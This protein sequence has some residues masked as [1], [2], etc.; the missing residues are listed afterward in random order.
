MSTR[1]GLIERSRHQQFLRRQEKTPVQLVGNDSP[2]VS[3]TADGSAVR[4]VWPDTSLTWVV[5]ALLDDH[6]ERSAEFFDLDPR[7]Q[8]LAVDVLRTL[9]R[10]ALDVGQLDD[11]KFLAVT[12]DAFRDWLATPMVGKLPATLADG[13]SEAETAKREALLSR[14]LVNLAATAII[15]DAL[16][17]DVASLLLEGC[18][19]L[20]NVSAAGLVMVTPDGNLEVI[21]TSNE[22]AQ[23][24]AN[25]EVRSQEGPCIECLDSGEPVSLSDLNVVN[26]MWPRFGAEGRAAGFQ[27]VQVLPMRLRETVIGVL[28]LFST[29]RGVMAAPDVDTGQ[30]LADMATI[31]VLQRRSEVDSQRRN[32][33]RHGAL[34]TR[35]V[36]EQAKAMIAQRS[37]L[38]M[39]QAFSVLRS[40]SLHCGRG[41][42]DIAHDVVDARVS[43]AT[44]EP[45]PFVR[46]G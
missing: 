31:A 27:S 30:A 19:T 22:Q 7:S 3:R 11:Q 45:I 6:T 18:L 23:T 40:H 44:L 41:L 42:I 2:A 46:I 33:Q 39:D 38:T 25:F 1:A 17:P 8:F 13:R 10:A 16:G 9:T 14:T 12:I 29:Q 24:L 32:D 26:A 37:G 21:A 5:G 36:I 35:I 4:D 34:E 15:D 43:A 28:A 20:L